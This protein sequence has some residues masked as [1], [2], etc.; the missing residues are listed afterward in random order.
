[1]NCDNDASNTVCAWKLHE[2]LKVVNATCVFDHLHHAVEA[3]AKVATG[4]VGCFEKNRCAKVVTPAISGGSGVAEDYNRTC[5]GGGA[6]DC[7]FALLRVVTQ[8]SQNGE[9]VVFSTAEGS[10][11]VEP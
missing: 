6:T 10:G 2:T 1:M 3:A 5:V 4:G 7:R 8:A 11:H 9:A